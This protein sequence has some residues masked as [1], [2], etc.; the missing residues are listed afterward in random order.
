MKKIIVGLLGIGILS[1]TGC[2]SVQYNGSAAEPVKVDYPPLDTEMTVYVGDHMLKK[3]LMS[4]MNTL[5]V[6]KKITSLAY[7]IPPGIYPQIGFDNKQDFFNPIG[8]IKAALADPYQA[9]SVNKN[10]TKEVCVVTVFGAKPCMEA[11]DKF[12][13]GKQTSSF[14]KSFQQTLIYSGR[15]GDKINISY[16]EFSN[17]VA[18]P[19]FNN[20]VEYD[21]SAS[22]SIGYK[23]SLI[24]IINADNASITYKVIR[25]FPDTN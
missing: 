24:E 16:R 17:N 10:Q 23:G 11:K 4:E 1:M 13:I 8:I 6:S 14:D 7:D 18:R 2:T 19:A 21:L 25:N 5:K 12:T 3:G 22:S 20:D 15:I 9:I